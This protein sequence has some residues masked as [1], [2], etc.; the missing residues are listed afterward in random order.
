VRSR[1]TEGALYWRCRQGD[2]EALT[3]LFYSL[4][5]EMYAMVLP[6]AVDERAAR[7][8]TAVAW[9]RLLATLGS[10]RLGGDI[11]ATARRIVV[12]EIVRR[13]G[14]QAALTVEASAAEGQVINIPEPLADEL[15]AELPGQAHILQQRAAART[16]LKHRALALALA[17]VVA[18]VLIGWH[19]HMC[20]LAA[21]APVV[22]FETLQTRIVKGDLADVVRDIAA[23]LPEPYEA[24]RPVADTLRRVGLIL[25]EI[26][27]ASDLASLEGLRY[28]RARIEYHDLAW[29]TTSLAERYQGRWRADLLKVAPVLEEVANP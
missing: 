1:R 29:Q 24:D 5:G 25:E 12:R 22:R 9:R 21:L 15:M 18:G 28:I 23:E 19:L 10:W 11:P 26:T 7:E 4:G 27:N 8:V 2:I 6:A 14:K 20:R 13:W 16:R 3:T 17:G